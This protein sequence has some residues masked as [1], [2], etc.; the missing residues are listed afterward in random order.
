MSSMPETRYA[1]SGDTMW[2]IKSWVK[3]LS[4]WSS[5]TTDVRCLVKDRVPTPEEARRVAGKMLPEILPYEPRRRIG[6]S[7]QERQINYDAENNPDNSTLSQ[8][9]VEIGGRALPEMVGMLFK[10]RTC[11]LPPLGTEHP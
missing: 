8:E 10:E 7:G 5:Y 2:L 4:T 3:V 6:E 11:S 9:H 1:K